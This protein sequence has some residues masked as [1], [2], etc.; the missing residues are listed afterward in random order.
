MVGMIRDVKLLNVNKGTTCR[1]QSWYITT[2]MVGHHH[3]YLA[4]II[5][6]VIDGYSTSISNANCDMKVV[7]VQGSIPRKEYF[8]A[9]APMNTGEDNIQCPAVSSAY[10]TQDST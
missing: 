6:R 2:E 4:H 3:V 10:S 8:S 5:S 9:K 7:Q 1:Q